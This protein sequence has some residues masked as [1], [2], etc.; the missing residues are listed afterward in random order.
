MAECYNNKSASASDI[1]RCLTN[2]SAPAQTSQNILQNEI[3][4][5]QNR[6]Q[7]CLADCQDDVQV[8]FGQITESNVNAA[9]E[10]NASCA[11]KC[12]D[13]SIAMV[14]SLK[15]SLEQKLDVVLKK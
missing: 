3:A 14:G 9:R 8:K 4:Q 1:E 7:R 2:V 6:M 10:M 11:V 15:T 12:A 5:F 13:K